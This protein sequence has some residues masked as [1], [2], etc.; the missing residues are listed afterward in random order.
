MTM[1]PLMSAAPRRWGFWPNP[2]KRCG[3]CVSIKTTTGTDPNP[4]ILT[5]IQPRMRPIVI[6]ALLRRLTRAAEADRVLF[7][8]QP[9]TPDPASAEEATH[10]SLRITPTPFNPDRARPR[11]IVSVHL[12]EAALRAGNGVARVE[13][14]GPVLLGRLHM[15]LGDNCSINL[16]PLIDL[17]ASHIPVD[18]YEIPASLREHLLLR[19][20]ADVFPTPTR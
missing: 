9:P 19:Y 1:I 16:K 3:C 15:L 7:D 11:A 14:V 6:T 2:L 12:S 10:R 17:P 8:D 20:P 5:R 18:C 13:D 4:M